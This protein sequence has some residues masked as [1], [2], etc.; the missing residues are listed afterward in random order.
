VDNSKKSLFLDPSKNSRKIN[1]VSFCNRRARPAA[2]PS[3]RRRLA[4]RPL[5]NR[6]GIVEHPL[7]NPLQLA[8]NAS[9]PRPAIPEKPFGNRRRL[10]AKNSK[11]IRRLADGCGTECP[12]Y[13]RP[14]FHAFL[15]GLALECLV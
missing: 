9:F 11:N 12:P 2:A 8:R 6:P 15:S 7:D 1:R 14:F 13:K 3:P 5:M 4:S 10:I